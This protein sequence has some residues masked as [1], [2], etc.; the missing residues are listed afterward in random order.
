MQ[1]FRALCAPLLF[2]VEGNDVTVWQVRSAH[3]PRVLERLTVAELPALF[4]RNRDTWRPDA[5]HRAKS[6]GAVKKSY[7]LDF[8]DLGLL[9]A[10]EGEIHAKLDRLLV[11]TLE[12]A[13]AAQGTRGLDMRLLFHVVFRLLAAKVLQDRGHPYANTWNPDDLPSV[14]QAIESYYSLATMPVDQRRTVPAAYKA[15]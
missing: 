2:V 6:V 8:V 15:A 11:E 13:T 1:S 14:L 10:I 3:P 12:S 4:E 7:Q 9:P 5:I